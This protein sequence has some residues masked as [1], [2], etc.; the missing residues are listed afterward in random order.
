V[1]LVSVRA[2]LRAGQGLSEVSV[3]GGVISVSIE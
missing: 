1:R 3:I 2:C